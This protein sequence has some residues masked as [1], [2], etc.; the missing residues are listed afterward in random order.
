MIATEI[1]W[2]TCGFHR[3]P[4]FADDEL[5]SGVQAAVEINRGDQGLARVRQQRLLAPPSGF[6]FASPENHVLAESELLSEFR[7]R[8]GRHDHR[9]DL[10]LLAFGELRERAKERIRN[11]QTEHG[12]A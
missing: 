1:V 9:L 12:I 7:E 2:L 6:F 11:D 8:R 5:A 3:R 10:R 4:E